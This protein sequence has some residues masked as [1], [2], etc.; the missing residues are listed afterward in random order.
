MEQAEYGEVGQDADWLSVV[1][2][3]IFFWVFTQYDELYHFCF[4]PSG[5]AHNETRQLAGSSA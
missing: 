2:V 4:Y 1:F 3:G 5:W